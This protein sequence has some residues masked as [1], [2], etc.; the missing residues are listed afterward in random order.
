MKSKILLIPLFLILA[1]AGFVIFPPY[2]GRS[3]PQPVD[4]FWAPPVMDIPA[5]DTPALDSN[6]ER[7]MRKE[8][9][10]LKRHG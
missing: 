3:A 10:L 4:T 2:A 7:A 8:A 5:L 1:S 9:V 6:L